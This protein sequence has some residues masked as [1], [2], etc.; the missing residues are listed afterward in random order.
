MLAAR[1]VSGVTA[2]PSRSGHRDIHP[3]RAEFFE[4]PRFLR[5]DDAEDEGMV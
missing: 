2:M 3:P 4:A 5:D 1:T